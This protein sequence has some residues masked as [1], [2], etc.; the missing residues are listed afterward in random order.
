VALIDERGVALPDA[1]VNRY[2]RFAPGFWR[3]II[4]NHYQGS[5]MAI[6]A[7]FLGRVLP[8]PK[9]K[10]FLHDA[11]IGTRNEAQGGKTVFIDEPLVYYRRHLQNASQRHGLLRLVR[12]RL[13]LLIAHMTHAL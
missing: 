4:K 11:W 8:F 5:A 10:L 12:V 9:G 13:N 7:G 6:R 2:G 1:Q 3:N